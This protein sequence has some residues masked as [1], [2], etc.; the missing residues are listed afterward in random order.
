MIFYTLNSE[1][2]FLIGMNSEGEQW[3]YVW[4]KRESAERFRR[5]FAEHSGMGS[6]KEEF[7]ES[8][9][10]YGM[11]LEEFLEIQKDQRSQ[12]LTFILAERQMDQEGRAVPID[13][14]IEFWSREAGV[15]LGTADA[16]KATPGVNLAFR[17]DPVSFFL[18]GGTWAP[19]LLDLTDSFG[20]SPD[21]AA[22]AIMIKGRAN[23]VK[24]MAEDLG[25]P[26]SDVDA[27]TIAK[28]SFSPQLI[29]DPVPLTPKQRAVAEEIHFHAWTAQT[30]ADGTKGIDVRE[31]AKQLVAAGERGRTTAMRV[32]QAAGCLVAVLALGVFA[33]SLASFLGVV[34]VL[35]LSP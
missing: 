15:A 6:T 7:L 13:K 20:D 27:I 17:V 22:M 9:S 18:G 8:Y 4:D 32:G 11:T 25:M 12:G 26:I 24:I 30:Q 29:A 28:N 16:I 19:D 14:S 35:N 21:E 1:D 23:V 2:G 33:C 10:V 31:M 3:M 5:E 34:C